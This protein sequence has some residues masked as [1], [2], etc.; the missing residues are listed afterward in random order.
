MDLGFNLGHGDVR[1]LPLLKG[2]GCATCCGTWK[3]VVS[4]L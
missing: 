1:D 2:T 4:V 3:G